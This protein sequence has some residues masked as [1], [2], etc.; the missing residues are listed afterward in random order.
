MM[1]IPDL[2]GNAPGCALSRPS[3][4]CER[5]VAGSS[6]PCRVRTVQAG[7]DCEHSGLAAVFPGND[8]V[9]TP[10]QFGRL[11]DRGRA[12]GQRTVM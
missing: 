10:V 3:C 8:G 9:G 12:S 4:G 1:A 5:S 6:L 2:G 7:C 11:K